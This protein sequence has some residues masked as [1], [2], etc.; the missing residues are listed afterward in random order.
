MQAIIE[1]LPKER[2]SHMPHSKKRQA[3]REAAKNLFYTQGFAAVSVEAI[4]S[5]AHTSRVTF[6]KYYFGKNALVQE[7]FAE[8]KEQ[9][10]NRLECLLAQQCSLEEAAAALFAIQRESMTELY[11]APVLDD[12]ANVAD[13]E[14]ERFFR[15][16]E[17]EKYQFMRSFFHTLQQR[18]LIHHSLPPELIDL[19][20]RQM[21]SLMRQPCL[22]EL[23]APSPQ[24]LPQDIL[25][26]L[27]Y[28][29]T[30]REAE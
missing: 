28:G 26:L 22:A 6:Y 16:M 19:F 18:K 8:Q 12:I 2:Y 3:L 24:R 15:S 30:S 5:A 1:C 21:D 11:S 13:L 9:V 10:R 14:L 17:E 4:C 23:Y 29:L 25:Q 27:L 7:L 20:I